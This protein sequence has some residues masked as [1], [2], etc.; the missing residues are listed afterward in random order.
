MAPKTKSGTDAQKKPAAKKTATVPII[1]KKKAPDAKK[2]PVAKKPAQKQDRPVVANH[3][4]Q[5]RTRS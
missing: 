5:F 3:C 1:A 2:A 4:Q